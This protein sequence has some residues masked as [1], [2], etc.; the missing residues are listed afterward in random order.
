MPE[1][2]ALAEAR[3]LLGRGRGSLT[4]VGGEAGIGKSRLID[5]FVRNGGS[6][7]SVVKVECIPDA[8]TELHPIRAALDALYADAAHDAPP[9]VLRTIAQLLPHRVKDVV[10]DS[11]AGATLGRAELFAGL[12]A[13]LVHVSTKRGTI[14]VI[15]D[16]HWADESTLQFLANLAP[17]LDAM[18]L[19]LIATMR[20]E[21]FEGSDTLAD[22]VSRLLRVHSVRAIA[23]R[24]FQR[25]ELL[26]L[27]DGALTGRRALPPATIAGIIARCDGN[28]F[29]VE[30][31]LKTAVD[32][33]P[34]ERAALPLSIRASVRHRLAQFSAADRAVFEVAAVL[35]VRFEH[36]FLAELCG[37]EHVDVLRTLRAARAANLVDDVDHEWCRFHHA[38]TRE[39]IYESLLTAETQ[40]L[41]NRIVS[42]LERRPDADRHVETLAYHAWQARDDTALQRYSERAGDRSAETGMYADARAFY[43]RTIA[44]TRD[45]GD[46]AR[47]YERI[48]D[49]DRAAGDF[50]GAIAA[51]EASLALRLQYHE[52]DIAARIAVALAVERSNSGAEALVALERFTTEYGPRLG[53]A[54][55]DSVNVFRARMWTSLGRFDDAERLLAN[56]SR[57]S[58]LE[59]R[60]RANFLTAQLNLSEH[61]G[62]VDAWRTNARAMLALAPQLPPLLRSIQLANVA[63][64]GAWFAEREL[65]STALAEAQAIATHWGFEA[66]LA[67]TCAV[68]AQLAFLAGDLAGT[69]RALDAVARRPDVAPAMTLATRIGP[70]LG[71]ALADVALTRQWLPAP[72]VEAG[73]EPLYAAAGVLAAAALDDVIAHDDVHAARE[74]LAAQL[75]AFEPGAFIPTTIAAVAA[76]MLDANQLLRLRSS[77]L[78]AGAAA[79]HLIARATSD[80]VI[81]IAGTRL[82]EADRARAASAAEQF[83]D[84]GWP[85]F[86]ALALDYA[87]RASEARAISERCGVVSLTNGPRADERSEQRRLTSREWQVATLVAEGHSNVAIG[88]NLDVGI[89]T[90]EKH[91]SSILLKLGARSRA[92]IA[93]FVANERA[94][95]PANVVAPTGVEP[96]SS[97]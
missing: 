75:A 72:P 96:V 36:A 8:A 79:G 64:T 45:A 62:A 76:Q 61:R 71:V 60:V 84:A 15:E 33:R 65:A 92:Q 11:Y 69:R 2:A 41:H 74:Q 83:H 80:L 52:F 32:R 20:E 94:R 13:A 10:R 59:P 3:R 47:L 82:G 9:L 23:L 44:F 30:E 35:G 91:V 14:V 46:R 49:V 58:E 4:I 85:L 87:G 88:R 22:V 90:V 78:A 68:E 66:L 53:D 70:F 27:I 24:P 97:P 73:Q 34:A 25:D 56:L 17:R 89:K 21:P 95:S 50:T 28:P 93:T 51:L 42:A 63:Q 12:T 31:L 1:I 67:F 29:F 7:A 16:L 81:A 57:P 43:Q 26:E 38:L 40:A 86:E 5:H 19:M 48:G 55:R 54:A 39:A 18:R 77:A 37:R 6:T